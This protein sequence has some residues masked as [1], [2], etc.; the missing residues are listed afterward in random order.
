[1]HVDMGPS[2]PRPRYTLAAFFPSPYI[3]FRGSR[4][5]K[6]SDRMLAELSPRVENL[7]SIVIEQRRLNREEL[8]EAVVS[9]W[10]ALR[11]GF[12]LLWLRVNLNPTSSPPHEPVYC[13]QNP[14][15]KPR[16][17]Q[18]DDLI[19]Q[20]SPSPGFLRRALSR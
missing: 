3:S 13:R 6:E 17:C 9:A 20:W 12:S 15:F 18:K 4:N 14:D 7:R 19:W 8:R 5:V 11:S 2:Q 16:S 10:V 1:M